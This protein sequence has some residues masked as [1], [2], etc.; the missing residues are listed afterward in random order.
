MIYKNVR[1]VT[2]F[3]IFYFNYAISNFGLMISKKKRLI[4]YLNMLHW[5]QFSRF[6]TDLDL[7][8]IDWQQQHCWLFVD[9]FLCT[10]S[11]T[12]FS[13]KSVVY[14]S[15]F[16]HQS[17]LHFFIFYSLQHIGFKGIHHIHN[18]SSCILV[19]NRQPITLKL[20]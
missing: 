9:V 1:S 6:L 3:L 19:E 16:I 12:L 13:E 18:K 14:Y 20:V 11:E 10:E 2:Y 4:V 5:F 17:F 7:K 8:S 15:A